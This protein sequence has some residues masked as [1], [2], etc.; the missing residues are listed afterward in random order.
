MGS[1]LNR[2]ARRNRR[3]V[4]LAG[5]A[6]LLRLQKACSASFLLFCV[7]SAPLIARAEIWHGCA[8]APDAHDAWVASIDTVE[9]WHSP[10]FGGSWFQEV[11]GTNHDFYDIFFLDSLNG[12]T[13][14]T[15]AE[16]QHTT[17]GGNT[18]TWQ[19]FGDSKIFTRI[20]FLDLTH[21]WA[22]GGDAI[23]GRWDQASSTW[24][25]IIMPY[26]DFNAD[27]CDFY[28]ISFVD[29]LNGWMSAGK[30]PSGDTDIGGQG[31][32][33]HST[34][35]GAS[36]SRQVR[37]TIYDLFDIHFADLNTGWVVG[38]NDRTMRAYIAKTTDGGV[39]WSGQ[40]LDSAGMLRAVHFVGPEQG[41]AVGKF[42]TILHTSDGGANWLPQVSGVDSTLF[43]V[44]FAD[45]L[46]GMASGDS[47]I[48][49]TSDGGVTWQHSSVGIVQDRNAGPALVACG[50]RLFVPSLCRS[51]AAISA[52]LPQDAQ[53]DIAVFNQQGRRIRTLYAGRQGRGRFSLTWDGADQQ[54]VPVSD[55]VYLVRLVAGSRAASDKILYLKE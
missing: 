34:D 42:G 22:A 12:W 31:Y 37:D 52:E 3:T 8:L 24:Q 51:Q 15:I 28:G 7:F 10:D 45:S 19:G 17:D 38:G 25:Q 14:G 50:L 43:D 27:S 49:F 44:D 39:D 30:Y 33:A 23:M 13:C 54:G 16:V 41:W 36:W 6:E 29:T 53:V 11:V 20:Q 26:P 55:G 9:I 35:G 46:H 48:I 2:C 5:T 4:A 47:A 18:W 21:G 32:V 1:S 40:V